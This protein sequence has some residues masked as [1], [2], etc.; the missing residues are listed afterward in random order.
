MRGLNLGKAWLNNADHTLKSVS[1]THNFTLKK[2]L[3]IVNVSFL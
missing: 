1:E 3:A 2:L